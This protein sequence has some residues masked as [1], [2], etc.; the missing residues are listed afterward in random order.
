M[1]LVVALRSGTSQI[2]RELIIAFTKGVGFQVNGENFLNSDNA[3]F[4]SD[5]TNVKAWFGGIK[6]D[7]IEP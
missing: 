1:S 7:A 4:F 3:V 2:T 5:L 6:K